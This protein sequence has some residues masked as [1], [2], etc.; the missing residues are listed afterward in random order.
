MNS[1]QRTPDKL[2]QVFLALAHPVRR[3][4]LFS[5]MEGEASVKIIAK[6]FSMSMVAV[7]KH[8]KILER[9][10]LIKRS[11]NAQLRPSHL[12]AGPLKEASNWIQQYRQFWNESFDK[13]DEYIEEL[14]KKEKIM[15][16]TD[17]SNES[18]PEL[19]ITRVFNATPSQV[20]KMWTE[21]EHI[22]K[23]YGPKGFTVPEAKIDLRVGG[24]FLIHMKMPNGDIFPNPGVIREVIENEKI[25][26]S[27]MQYDEQGNLQ[28]EMLNTVTLEEQ[29]G[30]TKMTFHVVEVKT[31]P[32]V[33]PLKGLDHAWGQSFDKLEE[34]LSK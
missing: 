7:T 10:K 21:P 8:L 34:A 16:E 26:F 11:K 28:V 5:L 12:Q 6:P 27:L 33:Q 18:K 14:Q 2:S 23:W 3:E 15:S 30:K 32:G 29:D 20:Y 31:I 25:Q 9:A 4:I 24:E 1:H 19:T 17:Q 22:A 13:L